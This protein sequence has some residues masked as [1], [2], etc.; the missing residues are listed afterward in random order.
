MLTVIDN[1]NQI[2]ED[3]YQI[4]EDIIIYG[5]EE[6]KDIHSNYT[7]TIHFPNQTIS[8]VS[9]HISIDESEYEFIMNLKS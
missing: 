3:H 5:I 8:G 6:A 1:T 9:I 4:I 2:N 7:L